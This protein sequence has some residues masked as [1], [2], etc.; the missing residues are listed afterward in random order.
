MTDVPQSCPHRDPDDID[1]AAWLAALPPFE[2]PERREDRLR[3]DLERAGF[4]EIEFEPV[5]DAELVLYRMRP[6]TNP[7]SA[8]DLEAHTTMA[9]ILR[10]AGYRIGIE[11]LDLNHHG[12]LIE[13]G[14]STRPF[15]EQC[16]ERD[17]REAAQDQRLQ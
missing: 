11:D 3:R 12:D 1:P 9:E 15:A 13:G 14:F 6:G 5:P 16:A 10:G 4:A 17:A 8:T 7:N 2:E